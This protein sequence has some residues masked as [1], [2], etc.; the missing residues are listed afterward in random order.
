MRKAIAAQMARS[1]SIPQF[2]VSREVDV[3]D[4]AAS[5]D[6]EPATITDAVLWAT[7]TALTLHPEINAS[8][9]DGSPPTIVRH[10]QVVV[11]VAIAVDAG[12]I[13]P[14]IAGAD[15]LSLTELH[16]CRVELE[17]AARSGTLS[18]SQ[19]QGAT[20]T[21]SN[22]GSLGVDQFEALVNPPEAGILAVGAARR[23]AVVVDD[24][25]AA[26]TT[27]MLTF[28]GDHRVVDGAA[29]AR[30]LAA[31]RVLAL[32][33]PA[34][35]GAVMAVPID[36]SDD[37]VLSGSLSKGLRILSAF[38]ADHTALSAKDIADLTDINR[39]SVYRIVRTL[40]SLG[41]VAR[42]PVDAS[43]YS[44]TV[45]VF[46]L[47]FAAVQSLP[48]FHAILPRLEHLLAEFPD[49]TAV[50]YGELDGA[51]DRRTSSAWQRKEIIAINLHVG[52][53]LPAQFSSIGKSVLAAMEPDELDRFL[54]TV[55]VDVRTRFTPA[56]TDDL[57]ASIVKARET[58]VAINDQELT[59]G[60]RS[61]A[62][63]IRQ[64]YRVLGAVNIAL[65]AT[66]VTLEV[67]RERYGRRLLR[68]AEEI[69]NELTT[70]AV[71]VG[72]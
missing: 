1:A 41:F 16:E 24:S 63:P 19:L 54:E 42:N 68:V 71:A 21:V 36:D 37:G 59:V 35:P 67:L 45:R 55:D 23:R 53:R 33:S 31:R 28:A 11:G 30:F 57:Q 46:E 12:L 64:G 56:T 25:I 58:G 22:L 5:L 7:A 49:A 65:P 10:A 18:S 17:A 2:R 26:R 6:G 72:R 8:W 44:P 29:G 48:I 50:S 47:G 66:R 13:V 9:V 52:S 70:R 40:E 20:F 51:A 61:V 27:L 38:D 34:G 14:V 4:I 69:S 43:L 62:A 39:G 60:L 32:G 3:T 15:S